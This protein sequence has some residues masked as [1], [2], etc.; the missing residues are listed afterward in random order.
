[1]AIVNSVS[2]NFTIDGDHVS[3][4]SEFHHDGRVMTTINSDR[5]GKIV[6]EGKWNPAGGLSINKENVRQ[7]TIA[8]LADVK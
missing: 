8:A 4:S 3:V 1:M 5:H 6:K 7:A 2:N